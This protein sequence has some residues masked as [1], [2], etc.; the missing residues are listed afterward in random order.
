[1]MAGRVHSPAELIQVYRN[2]FP[3][4]TDSGYAYKILNKSLT[5][6]DSPLLCDGV[7]QLQFDQFN[8]AVLGF[9]LRGIVG[10]HWFAF[11]GSFGFQS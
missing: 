7:F 3:R 9:V 10:R 4:R 2:S 6:P 8:A 1:M 11:S 5:E